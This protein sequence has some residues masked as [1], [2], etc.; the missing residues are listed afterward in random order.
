M[1]ILAVLLFSLATFAN[2]TIISE[3]T[4]NL[5]VDISTAKLKWTNLGYGQ[6][7]FVKVIVPELAAPTVLNHRNVGEDG[8]C[9]F[10]YD[11]TNLEDVIGDNPGIENVDFKIT[12]SKDAWKTSEGV[13]KVR[14]TEHI[15]AEIR[16]FRF[17][18][19]LVHDLPERVAEDCI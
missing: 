1:K 5:P 19:N 11:T 9:L 7:F 12:V 10:T 17:M 2:T 8:P 15:E 4:V 13:C 18:H 16:G 14:L 3:R 6:T